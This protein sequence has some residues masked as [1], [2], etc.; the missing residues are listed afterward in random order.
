MKVSIKNPQCV[1]EQRF[2]VR[3]PSCRIGAFPLHNLALSNTCDG[4]HAASTSPSPILAARPALPSLSPSLSTGSHPGHTSSTRWPPMLPALCSQP[5]HC[6]TPALPMRF[7]AVATLRWHK[8]AQLGPVYSS[9]R[10]EARNRNAGGGG[11]LDLSSS[12]Q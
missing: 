12:Q 2:S 1:C 4:L 3:T 10:A 11:R 7:R 8:M 9:K 5:F 6:H